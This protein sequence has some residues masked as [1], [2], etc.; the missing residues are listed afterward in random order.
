MDNYKIIQANSVNT[1]INLKEVYAY[2]S[3]IISFLKRDI[4]T[5]YAQTKLGII[6]SLIQ[7]FAAA[8]II[9]LFFGILLNI[10][11]TNYP[12]I[13][14]AFPGMTAWY[15]FSYIINNSGTSVTNAQS[16]IKKVYFPKLVLPIYK[17]LVGMTELLIWLIAY[18]VILITYQIPVG[19]NLLILPIAITFN[20][21]VGFSIAVW[22]SAITV[23]YRD[24]SH[25][26]PYLIGFGI[27]VT[28]VFFHTDMFPEKFSF[29]MHINPMAGV[30]AL[31]RYCFIST[32]FDLK[33]L[34]GLF[35][36]FILL[37]TGLKYFRKVEKIIA[38]VI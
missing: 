38:D 16:V 21:L 19:Y 26:I 1:K 18:T 14:Y 17:S 30:I 13:V 12:F 33:Y 24:A 25:I 27:F 36:T 37:I 29:F 10:E 2:R 4:L 5:K 15:F 20:F 28:P 8:L 9:N 6:L 35:P 32:N 7:A 11:I 3:L 31:Y 34:W 22:L 23:R